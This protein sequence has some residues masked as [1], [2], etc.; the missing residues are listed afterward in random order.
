MIDMG[1]TMA[2]FVGQKVVCIKRD[3]WRREYDR[4]PM[5]RGERG[6]AFGELLTIRQIVED[7]YLLFVEIR[8]PIIKSVGEEAAFNPHH[9][10][11]VIERKTDI[12]IFTR[13]LTPTSEP[14]L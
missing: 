8:N 9:F 14:V 5:P 3:R 10:R 12:S 7:G 6:P 13:M 1:T 2:F 4:R 11:P